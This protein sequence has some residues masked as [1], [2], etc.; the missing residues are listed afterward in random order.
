MVRIA[1][2]EVVVVDGLPAALDAPEEEGVHQSLLQ[3]APISL[4][5]PLSED[6]P[7]D[8]FIHNTRKGA[9]GGWMMIAFV[10]AVIGRR[11][12]RVSGGSAELETPSLVRASVLRLMD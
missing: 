8:P 10:E 6:L 9:G 4:R 3:L 11:T 2:R 7:S 5:V 1:E 12:I